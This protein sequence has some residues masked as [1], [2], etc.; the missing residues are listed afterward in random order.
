MQMIKCKNGHIY[1]ADKL[2]SC[3]HCQGNVRNLEQE[4]NTYGQGQT[5]VPTEIAASRI[6]T[7]AQDRNMR[8]NVGVLV[9][10]SGRDVG[11]SFIL[12]EGRNRIGRA[13]NMEVSLP[14]EDT[15]SRNG[16]AEILY[17][18]GCFEIMP[19]KQDRQVLVNGREVQ[20]VEVL[21]DRDVITIGECMFSF[22]KFD[23]VYQGNIQ[24]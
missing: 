7:N 9:E 13:G 3:P 23:D 15:V 4:P 14:G 8:V 10:I 2:K 16:H 21:A 6:Y 11:R 12:Y 1:D 22:V 18:K 19:V 17:E 5:D 24:F 20:G